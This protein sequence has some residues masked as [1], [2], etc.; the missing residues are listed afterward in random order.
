M[1]RNMVDSGVEWI[2]KIPEGW[3]VTKIK[4][5]VRQPL[6]YGASESGIEYQT[7]LPRYIRIT[8]IS[9][10]NTLRDDGKLSLEYVVA[11]PYLLQDE[12][13]LFA[14]SGAT[15]GKTF[16]YKEKFGEA[17][18]AGYLIRASF[19]KK[20]IVPRFAF[21]NTLGAN[22]ESWKLN[23][24]TQ[25]TIQN[26]G[27]DRYNNYTFA[28]PSYVE[29]QRIAGFLDKKCSA[30][31]DVLAK[32][33]ESI[34]EYKKLKQAVITEAVTKG[35]RG[36][37]PMKDSGIDWIGQIPMEWVCRKVKSYTT[38]ITKGAT[39]KD[40]AVEQ[41]EHHSIRF[42]KS[43]NIVNNQF[44]SLPEFY[45]SESI[46]CGELKRSAIKKGDMLF[47]IAGASLGKVAI[48]RDELLPA[49]TNQA[50]AFM[51][52]SESNIGIEKFIWYVLQSDV[53][54]TFISLYA[55]QSA[56]PNISMENL[57]NMRIP[58][59]N[60]EEQQEIADYLDKKCAAIDTLIS[61]K[62]QF[63][64]EL[65]AYKKSLIYEYVTGKKEVAA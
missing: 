15:V 8:D 63:I 49:N 47:V 65:T 38:L 54:K 34:E 6:Q 21:Y 39:P 62:Q 16:F 45:I 41:S 33:Q 37:R 35:V 61:K 11:K 19:N 42:L 56:Q 2:G 23:A 9:A 48:I 24:F 29:Q 12:D 43:E 32:T 40:I 20:I 26:I 50:M 17:A 10:E 7:S 46:H 5:V 27:A 59:P 18:F 22:Y 30:I 4:Y 1:S 52:F 44:V 28:L 58:A 13:I 25:A 64:E 51:R 36:K 57:G 31:D 53:A 14:R 55:V 60:R 3:C